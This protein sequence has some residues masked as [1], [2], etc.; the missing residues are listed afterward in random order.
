[1]GRPGPSDPVWATQVPVYP[2][3]TLGRKKTKQGA[4]LSVGPEGARRTRGLAG[5]AFTPGQSSSGPLLSSSARWLDINPA[6][7]APVWSEE[8]VF[9]AFRAH[10]A[11]TCPT[12]RGL[13]PRRSPQSSPVRSAVLG[14]ASTAAARSSNSIYVA[15]PTRRRRSAPRRERRQVGVARGSG[16]E[17]SKIDQLLELRQASGT[18]PGHC[19]QLVDGREGS[20]LVS[21]VENLLSTSA[22]PC[23][24]EAASTRT[25]YPLE[26]RGLCHGSGNVLKEI[27][28]SGRG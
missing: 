8:G 17:G 3:A 14:A 20:V 6:R 23:A 9:P 15:A 4:S 12:S 24:W 16:P 7:F 21:V 18:Y 2:S 1:M 27:E 19:V 11:D 5:G 25:F 22:Q 26:G 10:S 13:E 28:S